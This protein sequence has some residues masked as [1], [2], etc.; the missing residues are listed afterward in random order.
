MSKI[1]MMIDSGSLWMLAICVFSLCT[2]ASFA[3]LAAQTG[4]L[5][6]PSIS[7]IVDPPEVLIP[8]PPPPAQGTMG[9][10]A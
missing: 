7:S 4:D 6:L 9:Q 8:K 3:N 5:L 10:M 1:R 2:A